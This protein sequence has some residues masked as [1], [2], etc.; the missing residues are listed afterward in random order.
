MIHA[1][2]PKCTFEFMVNGKPP[3]RSQLNMSK[4]KNSN[5][6]WGCP[7]CNT[8]HYGGYADKCPTCKIDFNSKEFDDVCRKKGLI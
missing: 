2:C 7:A 5:Q 1:K 3:K 8:K 6:C 4:H